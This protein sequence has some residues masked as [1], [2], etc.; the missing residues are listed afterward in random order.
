MLRGRPA[1][2]RSP[3]LEPGEDWPGLGCKGKKGDPGGVEGAPVPRPLPPLPLGW[4][5]D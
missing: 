4:S 1:A 2:S 3:R 5:P